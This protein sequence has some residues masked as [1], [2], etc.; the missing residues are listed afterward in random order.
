MWAKI[1]RKLYNIR[2]SSSLS[3]LLEFFIIKLMVKLLY[4]CVYYFNSFYNNVIHLLFV[5]F[6]LLCSVSDLYFVILSH[7]TILK[8]IAVEQESINGLIFIILNMTPQ[9]ILEVH[10]LFFF[11]LYFQFLIISY[12][13]FFMYQKV[14]T[15]E[16]GQSGCGRL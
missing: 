11:F 14:V 1:Y 10:S 7:Y 5:Y 12:N 13:F 3:V 16:E 6:F 9:V 8:I 15:R 2:Y 4:L